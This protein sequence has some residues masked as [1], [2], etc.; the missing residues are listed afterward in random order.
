MKVTVY[1]TERTYGKVEIDVPDGLDNEDIEELA[2]E[3]VDNGEVE[4]EWG[5]ETYRD[6]NV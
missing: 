3:K 4:I 2:E 5:D 1:I 6:Y